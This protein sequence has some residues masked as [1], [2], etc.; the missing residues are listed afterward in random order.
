MQV[1]INH[2]FK[3]FNNKRNV[4][5]NALAWESTGNLLIAGFDHFRIIMDMILFSVI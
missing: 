2:D 3:P 1:I 4:R 5:S